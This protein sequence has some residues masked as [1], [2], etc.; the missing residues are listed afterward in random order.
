M[1]EFY[2]RQGSILPILSMN[3][4]EDGRHDYMKFH[5][6]IQNSTITFTMVNVENGLTKIA[7]APAYIKKRET[8]G[9]T[10]QYAI[11]YDW[12]ERD[13]RENGVYEGIFEINFGEIKNDEYT[14][15]SGKLIM[16]IR[17]E[18]YITI[19]K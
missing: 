19:K 10:E 15:P 8:G 12:K 16:P 4:I 6:A 1:Q 13:T 3:L 2:I 17:E 18:L 9:C 11:C 7:K 14:Y 5:E